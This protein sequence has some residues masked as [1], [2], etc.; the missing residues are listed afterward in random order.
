MKPETELK[1]IALI[2]QSKHKKNFWVSGIPT[3][4]S[5]FERVCNSPENNK[6]FFEW[7]DM[8]VTNGCIE[9]TDKGYIAIERKLVKL[10]ENNKLYPL[11]EKYI[12]TQIT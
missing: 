10:A 5:G 11:F 12:F 1:Y 9:H 4:R 7:F 6:C 8:L 2:L 3:S